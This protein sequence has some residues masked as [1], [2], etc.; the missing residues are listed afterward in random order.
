MSFASKSV[1]T[2]GS[3]V[4]SCLCAVGLAVSMVPL[5]PGSAHASSNGDVFTT[6]DGITYMALGMDSSTGLRVLQVSGY[7]PNLLKPADGV[8]TIP[9]LVTYEGETYDVQSIASYAFKDCVA[10]EDVRVGDLSTGTMSSQAF[11]G[12]S[13]LR[14]IHLMGRAAFASVNNST[15]TFEGVSSELKIVAHEEGWSYGSSQ[16]ASSNTHYRV[17]ATMYYAV[18]F[19]QGEGANTQETTAYVRGV[20][21][22]SDGNTVPGTLAGS[23]ANLDDDDLYLDEGQPQAICTERPPQLEEG[24]AWYVTEG[25]DGARVDPSTAISRCCVAR[26][27]SASDLTYAVANVDSATLQYRGYAISPSAYV[28]DLNNQKVDTSL[29]QVSYYRGESSATGVAVD[30]SQVIEAGTYTMH[31][32]PA[33]GS[34]LQ[35]ACETTFKIVENAAEWYRVSGANRYAQAQSVD[36]KSVV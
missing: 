30:A 10:I 13:N 32:E 11:N 29:L 20:T 34:G 26:A 17:T 14:V 22:D 9:D 7:D 33:A 19:I 5:V 6:E 1:K 12:C 23:L 36:R 27:V 2:L 31:F 15:P 21:Q 25:E 8:L 24:Q 4:A 35:G 18:R 16:I 28:V 3:R